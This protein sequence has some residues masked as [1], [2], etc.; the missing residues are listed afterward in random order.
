MGC[1]KTRK[2]QLL[3]LSDFNDTYKYVRELSSKLSGL[4]NEMIRRHVLSFYEMDLMKDSTLDNKTRVNQMKEKYGMSLQNMGYDISKKYSDIPSNIRTTFNQKVFKK[5]KDSYWGISV[6][7]D[8]I[9]SYRKDSM[10][11]PFSYDN[12][13]RLSENNV[14]EF[15]FFNDVKF[16]LNFGRDRSNNRVIIDRI[17][18][19]EYKPLASHI[20]IEKNKIFLDLTYSFESEENVNISKDKIV[21]VDLGINRPMTIAREDGTYVKQIEIGGK[22]QLTR[23][24]IHKQK[25]T[26]QGS[27]RHSSGGHG[28]TKKMAK[29]ESLR[30]YEHNFMK[31]MN[32]T[33]SRELIKY[34]I[35][36]GVGTIKLENLTGITE[37]ANH[38]L[39]TWSY[40]QL[41][42]MIEYK[43]AEFGIIVLY[44]NPRYTSQTCPT[45]G[46]VDKTQRDKTDKTRFACLNENCSDFNENKDA[47]VIGALNIS[48]RDGVTANKKILQEKKEKDLVVSE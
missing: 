39:K 44:V 26:L 48:R 41:Q 37:H 47:D 19:N 33:L 27:L 5:I 32:D 16:K 17:L 22:I 9:P 1:I 43:A 18:S 34:C 28:V 25:R 23:L 7:K 29:M 38:F 3:P 35:S 8:S 45:C 10:A 36:E 4:G 2:I 13:I 24:S 14:Y 11:I 21:G 20:K 40:Y 12:N 46:N 31:T 30:R 6:N 15:R 42:Q